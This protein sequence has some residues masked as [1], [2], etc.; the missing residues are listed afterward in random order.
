MGTGRNLPHYPSD[1]EVTGLDLSRGMLEQARGSRAGAGSAG[2][3]EDGAPGIGGPFV[4][5]DSELL[6]F[7]DGSFDTVVDTL[8]VCT[9]VDPVRALREMARVCRQ[10]GRVLLFEHGRSDARWLAWLQE[11]WAEPHHRR[12][13][14]RLTREPRELA[15]MA[16]LELRWADRSFFGVFHLIEAGPRK[17]AA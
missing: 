16:G 12:F 15:E 11:A 4:H 8:T 9:Y 10:D 2:P 13:G 14:C 1:C 7:T 5:G 6:P 17:T 3:G